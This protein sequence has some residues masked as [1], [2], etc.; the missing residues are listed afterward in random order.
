MRAIKPFGVVKICLVL[1]ELL[2]TMFSHTIDYVMIFVNLWV[3][4]RSLS[5]FFPLSLYPSMPSLH[6]SIFSAIF[7][8]Q[9][10]H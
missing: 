4:F 2:H 9:K 5:S 8:C 6:P 1:R 3:F 10:E 7:P